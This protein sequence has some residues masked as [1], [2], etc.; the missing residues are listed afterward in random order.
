MRFALLCYAAFSNEWTK[1]LE[2]AVMEKHNASQARHLAARK[3]GPNLRLMP[4]SAAVTIRS[5][6]EPMVFDGPFAETKE[7]LLGF[8]IF[9][10]DSL[11]EA[12]EIGKEYGSHAPGGSLEVRPIMEYH[13]GNFRE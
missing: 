6:A 5:G 12:I 10:A 9:E 13:P 8:W 2:D 3:L 1:E 11:E 7:Q 4:P